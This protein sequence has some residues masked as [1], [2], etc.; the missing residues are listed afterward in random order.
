MCDGKQHQNGEL[1]DNILCWIC[2]GCGSA[3]LLLAVWAAHFRGIICGTRRGSWLALQIRKAQDE[4]S[5]L[6]GSQANC[7]DIAGSVE[8]RSLDRRVFVGVDGPA[9]SLA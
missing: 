7:A 4:R 3:T 1:R 2:S 5:R 9:L 6:P 8:R